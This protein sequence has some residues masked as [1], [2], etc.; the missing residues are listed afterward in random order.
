[1]MEFKI[2]NT[3]NNRMNN[4]GWSHC[5]IDQLIQQGVVNFCIAPGSRST[6]LALAAARHPKANVK[7]HF[8]ER[9]LGFYALGMSLT[10]QFPTAIIVTSG[11]AVGNLLPAVME[12]YHSHV[13]LILLT[14]DRP[15]ELRD[16]G[17]QQSTDQIKIFHN[18]VLWQADL[19]CPDESLT[20]DFIRS[21]AAFAVFQAMRKG[22]VHLNCQF[23]EPLFMLAEPQ[24]EGLC[25]AYFSPHLEIDSQAANHC[26]HQLQQAKQGV[27]LIGRLP[28]GYDLSPIL[29]LARRL[30]WPIW[31]DLLSQIRCQKKTDESIVHFDLAIRSKMAPNPDLI[32]HLGGS[33]ISKDLME[34]IKRSQVPTLHVHSHPERIDPLHC[35]PTR[36]YAD[37][38]RFCQALSINKNPDRTWLNRFKIIDALIDKNID[39]HFSAPHLFTEADMMRS[40][41]AQLPG[42]WSLFLSNSMPIRDANRFFF[43]R[44]PKFIFANRGLAGIDGQIATAAGIACSLKTPLLAIIGDQSCLYDLNSISL[45]TKIDTPFLLIISNNFGGGI[46][47]QLPVAQEPDHFEKLFGLPHAW[48]FDRIA[49]MFDL[50]YRCASSNDWGEIFSISK[51]FILEVNTSREENRCFKKKLE[52]KESSLVL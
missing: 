24:K 47:S 4:N 5:L 45:L 41:G 28:H 48:Q 23:R 22:P 25:Q 34:W 31:G 7:V 38:A 32:L 40:L 2:I 21:Q 39:A 3:D 36:I 1:M 15:A 44:N 10:K 13:P 46:F 35:R 26:S 30:S 6:P 37:P 52:S 9:G 20:E 12:A 50:P 16:S 8:D 49:Q 17:A 42:N 29:S 27:I 14:A 33:F 51:A 43:P 18:F 19:P 11:T